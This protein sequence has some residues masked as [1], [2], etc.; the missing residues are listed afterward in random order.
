MGRTNA[1]YRDTLRSI[2]GE[3]DDFERALRRNDRE[4]FQRL[5][6][7]ARRYAD[8]AGNQNPTDPMPAILLSMLLAQERERAT[9][10][11]RV[12]ELE[13]RLDEHGN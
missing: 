8:A 2:E 11:E 13:A 9:L 3:W 12:D 1:T 5:F 10:A 4:H 6:E 7:H